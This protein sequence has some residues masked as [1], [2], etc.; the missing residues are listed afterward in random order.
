MQQSFY[1]SQGCNM[2][3]HAVVS[4]LEHSRGCPCDTQANMQ[5]NMQSG[6]LPDPGFVTPVSYSQSTKLTSE[7]CCINQHIGGLAAAVG[8]LPDAITQDE[9]ALTKSQC[10]DTQANALSSPARVRCDEVDC[11][12]TH[13]NTPCKCKHQPCPC[14][15]CTQLVQPPASLGWVSKPNRPSTPTSASVLPFSTVMPARVCRMSPGLCVWCS[16]THTDAEQ[17]RLA[18]RHIGRRRCSHVD[19]GPLMHKA[20]LYGAEVS[21]ADCTQAHM[22]TCMR[23]H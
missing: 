10:R 5:L 14:I 18:H 7:G 23:C 6:C 11:S 22:L 21:A 12:P 8:C 9:A 2:H 17:I 1:M 16:T 3:Q 15:T 4:S 13:H 19:V 20:A